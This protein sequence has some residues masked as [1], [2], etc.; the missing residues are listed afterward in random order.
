MITD[1]DYK[2]LHEYS[3]RFSTAWQELGGGNV[4]LEIRL[5]KIESDIKKLVERI[6]KLEKGHINIDH[7]EY[8]TDE[9][10]SFKCRCGENK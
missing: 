8:M 9:C 10:K 5:Q 2:I 7:I 3:K 4:N 1:E 6:E